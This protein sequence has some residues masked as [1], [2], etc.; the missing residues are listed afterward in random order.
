VTIDERRK[1]DREKQKRSY[2]ANP[3]KHRL[4]KRAER[5]RIRDGLHVPRPR[6]PAPTTAPP[7]STIS[8]GDR[9]AAALLN[10]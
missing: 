3:E 5:K 7:T 10:I 2:D 9:I 4:R 6:M 8:L 1:Q